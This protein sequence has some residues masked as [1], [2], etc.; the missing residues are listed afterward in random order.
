MSVRPRISVLRLR[1]L[2]TGRLYD[3]AEKARNLDLAG[4]G[5]ERREATSR[6]R[7]LPPAAFGLS[8]LDAPPG[9]GEVAEPRH[10]LALAEAR[11][12]VERPGRLAVLAAQQVGL[13][14]P[15]DALQ[16]CV[17]GRPFLLRTRV[18]GHGDD[19]A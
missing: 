3:R 17:A 15:E 4:R 1:Q 11:R 12:A 6:V 7:E 8:V 10:E 13:G 16:A 14:A 18:V 9:R 2:S 19:R 5:E